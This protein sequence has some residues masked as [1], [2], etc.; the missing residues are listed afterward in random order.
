MELLIRDRV[1]GTFFPK[2]NSSCKNE[3]PLLSENK[4]HNDP[5]NIQ[6]TIPVIDTGNYKFF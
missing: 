2:K 4:W 6:I 3:S 1:K 5:N